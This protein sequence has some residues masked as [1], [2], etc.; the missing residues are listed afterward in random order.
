MC[1]FIPTSKL[2]STFT[3]TKKHEQKAMKTYR[4]FEKNVVMERCI[5]VTRTAQ[6]SNQ[7]WRKTVKQ[8]GS[9]KVIWRERTQKRG[10]IFRVASGLLSF[11][12]SASLAS[13][14]FWY[15]R[16]SIIFGTHACISFFSRIRFFCW[17]SP[18]GD[19]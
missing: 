4:F 2:I 14:G 10:S 12:F 1:H 6:S 3:W 11:P 15:P 8:D 17:A 13:Q 9:Q 16:I 19:G 5:P 18:K 7:K